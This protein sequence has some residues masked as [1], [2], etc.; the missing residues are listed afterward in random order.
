MVNFKYIDFRYLLE[1]CFV[2]SLQLLLVVSHL[3]EVVLVGQHGEWSEVEEEA[4]IEHSER[5]L[6][7]SQKAEEAFISWEGEGLAVACSAFHLGV[8]TL[9]NCMLSL[10]HWYFLAI[11]GCSSGGFVLPGMVLIVC[12]CSRLLSGVLLGGD[13][14]GQGRCQ[15]RPVPAHTSAEGNAE[16]LADDCSDWV[17]TQRLGV[18]IVEACKRCQGGIAHENQSERVLAVQ[19]DDRKRLEHQGNR[20]LDE[21][22][23]ESF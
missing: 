1:H 10:I 5:L 13:F 21:A 12:D 8:S 7:N 18:Q 14:G 17:L 9:C 22:Q 3:G 20:R 2:H 15:G 4:R 6:H 11:Y 23:H 16:L 19:V